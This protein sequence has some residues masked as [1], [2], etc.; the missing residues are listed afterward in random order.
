MHYFC[1]RNCHN[2]GFMSVKYLTFGRNIFTNCL[3]LV[4]RREL[5]SG[6]MLSRKPGVKLPACFPG[7]TTIFFWC[8]LPVACSR[9]L[10]A[11]GNG[12]SLSER[13][14]LWVVIFKYIVIQLPIIM[15][16]F[17]KRDIRCY[18]RSLESLRIFV[19]DEVMARSFI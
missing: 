13:S 12:S 5:I 10:W 11:L 3:P 19:Y 4:A 7:N 8:T 14:S 17:K 16:C 2:I 6:T 15:F 1:L 9:L 18:P